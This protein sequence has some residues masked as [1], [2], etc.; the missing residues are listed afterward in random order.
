MKRI[1]FFIA[2][3]LMLASCSME[4]TDRRAFPLLA[5]F[6]YTDVPRDQIFQKDSIFFSKQY[7]D[8]KNQSALGW[9]NYIG[10]FSKLNEDKT[11]VSGGFI[12]SGFSGKVKEGSVETPYRSA[13]TSI[14]SNN[15]LVYLQSKDSSVMPEQDFIFSVPQYGTCTPILCYVTNTTDVVKSV[16]E[17]FVVGDKMVLSATGYS[18]GVKTGQTEIVLAEYSAVRDSVVTRWTQ[19]DLSK[20]GNVDNIDFEIISSKADVPTYF[21]LDDFYVYLTL[22]Y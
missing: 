19:F 2:A 8:D 20:L 10:F 5:T 6:D 21:C 17:N 14:V 9:G 3:T 22:E 11:N 13:D 16:K 1:L 18:Q 15:Y 4:S 7:V 12:L